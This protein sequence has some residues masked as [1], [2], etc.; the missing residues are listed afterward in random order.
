MSDA[1]QDWWFE[2]ELLWPS[3][4]TGQAGP[5][6]G[7]FGIDVTEHAVVDATSGVRA[8]LRVDKP[9]WSELDL[10]NRELLTSG[11]DS[12]FLLV[13]LGFQFD[14]SG[15][16]GWTKTRYRHARCAARI[17]PDRELATQPTVYDILPKMLFEGEPPM[18]EITIGPTLE[19][20]G[21]KA[22]VGSA[23]MDLTA[24]VIEPVVVGW[25]GEDECEPYWELHP[26]GKPLIGTRH[27]WMIVEIP[28]RAEKARLAVMAHAQID[29]RFGPI[30]VG[31]RAHIWEKRPTVSVG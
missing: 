15:E 1:Q 25:L 23:R 9:R 18:R 29:T 14:L 10:A 5:L 11:E 26:K 6:G 21:V 2:E 3:K 28:G 27:F 13:R 22:S 12:R 7:D 17:W 30:P 20:R 24:G 19:I 16:P 8:T 31:P 4:P